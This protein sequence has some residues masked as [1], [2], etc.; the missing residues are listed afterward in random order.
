MP[1]VIDDGYTLDGCTKSA[2]TDPVTGRALH[3][4]LPEVRFKYRP[5]L[6]DSL[7]EWRHKLRA[8]TSGYA[9]VDAT[10]ILV[11]GHV[12]SWDVT[13]VAGAPAPITADTVRKLPE[14]ILEQM[15]DAIAKWAPK[16]LASALG[17]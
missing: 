8:A 1:L 10:A 14:P 16:N 13:T 9:S 5:A 11:A 2:V 6:P 7:A 3:D 12:V 17:N 15:V 4:G